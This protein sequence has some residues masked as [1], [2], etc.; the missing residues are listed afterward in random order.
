MSDLA[1]A[2][3]VLRAR[4]AQGQDITEPLIAWAKRAY[5]IDHIDLPEMERIVALALGGATLT[6]VEPGEQMIN[7]PQETP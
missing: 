2:M 7:R 3:R 5:A 1:L 6:W 4:D